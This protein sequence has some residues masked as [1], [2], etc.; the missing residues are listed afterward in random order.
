MGG[1]SLL[2]SPP[3]SLVLFLAPI[4]PIFPHLHHEVHIL[5]DCRTRHTLRWESARRDVYTQR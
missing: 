5:I 3:T 1:D 2:L 4:L